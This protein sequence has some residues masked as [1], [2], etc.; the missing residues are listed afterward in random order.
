MRYPQLLIYETDR[1]LAA[2]L[3]RLAD[4][5]DWLLREPRQP[6]AILRLLDRGGPGLL[7]LRLSGD[8]ERELAMLEQVSWLHPDAA[9]V[10]IADSEQRRLSGL[11]WDLGVRWVLLPPHTR[12]RLEEIVTNLMKQYQ[13]AA[14]AAGGGT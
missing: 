1:R 11:A 5:N 8:L 14:P 6:S 12:E 4:K 7:L 13:P 9:T 2:L 3:Q 10:L